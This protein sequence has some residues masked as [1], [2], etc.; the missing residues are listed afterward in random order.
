MIPQA[1]CPQCGAQYTGWA[2]EHKAQTCEKCGTKLTPEVK[3]EK[4][5][6]QAI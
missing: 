2:L 3:D 4:A 1:I 5:T 6:K